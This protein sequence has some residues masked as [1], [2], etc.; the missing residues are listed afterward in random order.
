MERGSNFLVAW[1]LVGVLG[2]GG[3]GRLHVGPETSSGDAEGALRGLDGEAG[4]QFITPT[5]KGRGSKITFWG[6]IKLSDLL[7]VVQFG[8]EINIVLLL[9][10]VIFS[11]YSICYFYVCIYVNQCYYNCTIFGRTLNMQREDRIQKKNCYNCIYL[12]SCSLHKKGHLNSIT[13]IIDLVLME[14]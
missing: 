14:R 2:A 10:F 6:G 5:G 9:L 1:P 8:I 13:I 11:V 7:L 12:L 3:A 4:N